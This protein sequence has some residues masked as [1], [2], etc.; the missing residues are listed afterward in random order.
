MA[1]TVFSLESAYP[2]LKEKGFGYICDECAKLHTS[3]GKRECTLRR[4]R[5]IIFLEGKGLLDDFI[6]KCWPNGMPQKV[7][8]NIPRCRKFY[9][10]NI[11][12]IDRAKRVRNGASVRSRDVKQEHQNNDSLSEPYEKI[13]QEAKK[14]IILINKYRTKNRMK[15]VFKESDILELWTDIENLCISDASF[16]KFIKS[17]YI[18]FREKTRDKNQNYRNKNDHYFIWRFPD[19]FWKRD[20]ITKRNMDNICIIRSEYFHSEIDEQ[21]S[22]SQK[23]EKK[24]FLDV[25]EELTGRRY[26]PE[27]TKDFQELQIGVMKQ[28]ESAME[29]L[30][31]MVKDELNHSTN[32]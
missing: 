11:N 20:K 15:P 32:H 2:Y 28:F 1:E 5:I 22:E 24:S 21:E 4:G 26:I 29:I 18:F 10:D 17:L 30:L 12:G 8:K 19:V 16:L 3:N 23:P 9:N 27:T 14:I 31:Q 7:K 25:V 13:V 6:K